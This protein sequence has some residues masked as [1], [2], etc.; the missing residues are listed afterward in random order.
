MSALKQVEEIRNAVQDFYDG[1]TFATEAIEKVAGILG[2][3]GPE[4]IPCPIH[5]PRT[6]TEC[7]AGCPYEPN[8]CKAYV[9]KWGRP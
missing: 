8:R 3:G 4:R 7:E 6:R 5:R 1:D 9:D 2:M